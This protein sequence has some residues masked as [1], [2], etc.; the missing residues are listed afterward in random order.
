MSCTVTIILG[1]YH[2]SFLL[3]CLSG[4]TVKCIGI[5]LA[6]PFSVFLSS[7]KRPYQKN[8]TRFSIHH[9]LFQL[10]DSDIN[11]KGKHISIKLPEV[12][13]VLLDNSASNL[14]NQILR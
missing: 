5:K 13:P 3:I 11:N 2:G 9:A 4:K 1:K 14:A 7:L 12:M 10:G 6:R 8:Q